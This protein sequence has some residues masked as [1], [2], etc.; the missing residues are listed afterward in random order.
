MKNDPFNEQCVTIEKNRVYLWFGR[1]Y[2]P[3]SSRIDVTMVYNI[4]AAITRKDYDK[5]DDKLIPFINL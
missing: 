1:P 2:A 3:T 4:A 5:I